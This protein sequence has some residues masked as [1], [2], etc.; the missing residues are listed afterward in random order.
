MKK[1]EIGKTYNMR[2][3]CDHNCIWSFEVIDRTKST[4]KLKDEEGNIKTCRISKLST[5]EELV[6][7]FGSYSMAPIL[8]AS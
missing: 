3:I 7:P 6:F 1:F 2:S 5:T 4:I 8:R